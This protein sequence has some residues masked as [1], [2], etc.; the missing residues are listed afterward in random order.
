MAH[1][2]ICLDG[3][4]AAPE[5][6]TGIVHHVKDSIKVTA[7]SGGM[8]SGRPSVGIIAKLGDG[9]HVFLEMSMRMFLAAGA[10]FS[11]RYGTEAFAEEGGGAGGTHN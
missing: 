10:A 11:A 6:A 5:L 2:K 9:S 3:D 4:G 1:I 7:L 8:E